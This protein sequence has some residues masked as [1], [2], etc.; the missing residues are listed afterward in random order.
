MVSSRARHADGIE[1]VNL[2]YGTGLRGRFVSVSMSDDGTGGDEQ[3]GDAV[4]SARIPAFSAGT[5]V[6]YYVEAVAGDAASTVSYMPEGSS[7]DVYIY[8]VEAVDSD[9]NGLV[10]NEFMAS[11][12]L[13]QADEADDDDEQGAFHANFKLSAGG[14]EIFDVSSCGSGIDLVKS[15]EHTILLK[16]F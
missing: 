6:R 9:V 7:Y 2:Y 12:D 15:G 13:I 4:Y 11:N 1:G 16:V 5:Y 3:A 14:E 8:R 10:I